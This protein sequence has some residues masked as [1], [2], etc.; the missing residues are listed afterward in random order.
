MRIIEIKQFLEGFA[1]TKKWYIFEP[2]QIKLLKQFL[3]HLENSDSDVNEITLNDFIAFAKKKSVRL[4]FLENYLQS[5]SIDAKFFAQWQNQTGMIK[6][7]N[8][9]LPEISLELPR[10]PHSIPRHNSPAEIRAVAEFDLQPPHKKSLPSSRFWSKPNSLL[11]TCIQE[12]ATH[13][14]KQTYAYERSCL[15]TGLNRILD[16]R[17]TDAIYVIDDERIDCYKKI[18]TSLANAMILKFH[19]Q[20]NGALQILPSFNA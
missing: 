18:D 3:A 17:L 14:L 19:E 8:L 6:K 15:P 11:E 5:N 10:L 9:V 7:I 20:I 1:D 2:Q 16:E 4:V 13:L 12:V